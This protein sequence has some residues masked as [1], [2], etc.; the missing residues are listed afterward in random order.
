MFCALVH[1]TVLLKF[2]RYIQN[3]ILVSFRNEKL[4]YVRIQQLW[5]RR[6]NPFGSEYVCWKRVYLEY[7]SSIVHSINAYFRDVVYFGERGLL[8]CLGLF[9][10][11]GSA[12]LKKIR[13]V[14]TAPLPPLPPPPLPPPL[15]LCTMCITVH[16]WRFLEA[17]A[18]SP[19][20]VFGGFYFLSIATTA[21]HSRTWLFSL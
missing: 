14:G 20:K 13:C 21:Q 19:Q 5:S 16:Y 11:R 8:R 10:A 12:I 18:R 3:E 15:P 6:E 1:T 9:W 4:L 7:N 2:I 17:R